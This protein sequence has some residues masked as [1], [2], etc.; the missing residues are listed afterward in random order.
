MRH[1]HIPGKNKHAIVL[2]HGTGGSASSLFEIGQKLDPEAA[3]IGFQGEVEE[4]GMARYFARYSD[5]SFDLR[6]L[7]SATYDFKDT[8]EKMIK[9][10]GLEDFT[11]TVVGYSNG[12]NLAVNVFKEFQD[13]PIKNA[14][15]FHPSPVRSEIPFKE[16]PNLQ[17]F[18]TSGDNDPYITI[19]QFNQL[20]EQLKAANIQVETLVH[21]YGHQLVYE[22]IEQAKALINS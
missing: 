2:L 12:A 3:L 7:A 1:I 15:L 22:E 4:Q 18:I 13:L 10:Y 21:H 5:G 9:H 8:L 6:S 19:D 20:H 11:I 14:L 16:Q 17:M